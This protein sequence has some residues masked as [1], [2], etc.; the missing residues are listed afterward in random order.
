MSFA[1]LLSAADEVKPRLVRSASFIRFD[2]RLWTLGFVAEDS[3]SATVP[4]TDSKIFVRNVDDASF[5][6]SCC[7][8]RKAAE[9]TESKTASIVST[10]KSKPMPLPPLTVAAR[11]RFIVLSANILNF[12]PLFVLCGNGKC[13]RTSDTIQKNS[14]CLFG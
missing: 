12:G 6:D 5:R 4:S 13:V 3:V 9:R 10:N 14:I 1:S 11:L 8:G 2:F 7:L